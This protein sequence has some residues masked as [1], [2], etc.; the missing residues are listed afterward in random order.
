MKQN[1]QGVWQEDHVSSSHVQLVN[2][3]IVEL[4][5]CLMQSDSD[6]GKEL[7]AKIERDLQDPDLSL[8]DYQ[9]TMMLLPGGQFSEFAAGDKVATVKGETVLLLGYTDTWKPAVELLPE[10]KSM[11]SYKKKLAKV[12]IMPTYPNFVEGGDHSGP[13]KLRALGLF[14]D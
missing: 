6:T 14:Y 12:H 11:C 7:R 8:A 5:S 4:L 9:L 1:V 2:H 13:G 10:K 3:Q